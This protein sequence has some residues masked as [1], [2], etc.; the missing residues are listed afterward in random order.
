[1]PDRNARY[2]PALARQCRAIA[3]QIKRNGVERV[4]GGA[5]NGALRRHAASVAN[6][7][8]QG[9]TTCTRIEHAVFAPVTALEQLS[10]AYTSGTSEQV[11]DAG[12]NASATY[13][14]AITS[15]RS[16]RVRNVEVVARG[17]GEALRRF[18]KRQAQ[19]RA[20]TAN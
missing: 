6:H 12:Q 14:A 20:W 19:R 11:G 18:E 10:A 16:T 15:L 9:A 13:V 5:I 7:G 4:Y 1:M 8:V 2:G 17:K 3:A